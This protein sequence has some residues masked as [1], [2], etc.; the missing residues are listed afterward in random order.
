MSNA[1]QP[2]DTILKKS[3]LATRNRNFEGPPVYLFVSVVVF[4]LQVKARL[5]VVLD[6]MRG[7]FICDDMSRHKLPSAL[8]ETEFSTKGRFC[9]K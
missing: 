1:L 9:G 3:V 4:V 7:T 6:A 2:I 5:E 8:G